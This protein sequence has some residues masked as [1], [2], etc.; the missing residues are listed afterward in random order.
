MPYNI[1]FSNL[2][3][4]LRVDVSGKRNAEDAVDLWTRVGAECERLGHLRVLAILDLTGG[5]PTAR[6]YDIASRYTEYG[7]T[8]MHRI[9]IVT[10]D[11]DSVQTLQFAKMVAGNRGLRLALF[12]RE[13][14]ALAWLR[15]G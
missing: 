2:G 4:M 9:A 1:R 5:L 6:T 8:P 3:D 12:S 15:D 10:T 13:E 14:T 7:L 11:A